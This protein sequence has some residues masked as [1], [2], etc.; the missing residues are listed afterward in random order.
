MQ[1]SVSD[2]GTFVALGG[3]CSSHRVASIAYRWPQLWIYPDSTVATEDDPIRIPDSVDNVVGAPELTAVV[4]T[5]LWQATEAEARDGLK[6]FTV[7]N[8]V[9]ALGDWPGRADPE[10]EATTGIQHKLFPTF[11][12]VLSTPRSDVSAVLDEEL[13][14]EMTVDGESVVES[15][16]TD[17][18]FSI[19]EMVAH[20]SHVVPLEENDVVA[21]GEPQGE[22][23][24]LDRADVVTCRIEGV[25]ELRNSITVATE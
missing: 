4:G 7:S 1:L 16:T 11:A 6:G 18:A 2:I 22:T 21:L 9:S 5:D 13:A 19:P 25:G 12:P 23:H 3:T 14:I 17:Y 20:A 15:T 24:Y 10:S 8:D